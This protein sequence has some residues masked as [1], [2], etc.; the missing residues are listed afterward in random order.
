MHPPE[1]HRVFLERASA[2]LRGDA[3]FLGLAAAGS[4]ATGGMDEWSDLDL[5][6][7][8]RDDDEPAI[9]C[10]RR[11]IAESLGDLIAAFTAEHVGE[12]RI[13]ICLYDQPSL[14]VDLKFVT[15]GDLRIGRAD[16][17]VVLWERDHALTSALR[18]SSPSLPTLDP[19]WAED[20]FWVWVHYAA[21]KLARRELF[22]AIDILSYVRARVL[23]P[24]AKQLGGHPP[25]GMRRIERLLPAHSV[26]FRAT[27]PAGH[28]PAEIA[29]AIQATVTLYLSLRDDPGAPPVQRNQRAEAAALQ[30]HREVT[31]I[32]TGDE[33]ERGTP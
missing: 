28:D 1:P 8:I 32:I 20:R 3:R 14:H 16:D 27:L 18:G 19:Q 4:F 25:Y 31:S 30:F 24:L 12:P 11:Q 23:G 9:M 7:V 22:E 6:I 26:A 2:V 5:I 33:A 21:S 10:Q 29:R 15:L 17:P 13:L